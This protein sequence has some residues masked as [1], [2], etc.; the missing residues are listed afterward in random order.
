MTIEA[1]EAPAFSLFLR[2]KISEKVWAWDKSRN[3]T[4]SERSES[5]G[6]AVR[7]FAE[8]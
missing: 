6:L 8:S 1:S 2:A 4:P 3:V 5:R 7:T